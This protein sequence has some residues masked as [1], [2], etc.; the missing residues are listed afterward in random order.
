MVSQTEDCHWRMAMNGEETVRVAVAHLHNTDAKKNGTAR[1]AFFDK[2]AELCAGGV[3]LLAADLNLAM[4]GLVP[5]MTKRGVGCTLSAY[6]MELKDF[7]I[8]YDTLG[9]WTIGPMDIV[10]SCRIAPSSHMYAGGCHPQMLDVHI[11]NLQKGF[12]VDEHCYTSPQHPNT[13]HHM[14]QQVLIEI[15]KEAEVHPANDPEMRGAFGEVPWHDVRTLPK[16]CAGGNRVYAEIW[17]MDKEFM[18]TDPVLTYMT[19]NSTQQPSM[20]KTDHLPMFPATMEM[21]AV[22]KMWDPFGH[23]WGR[24]SH[25][26]LMVAVGL[27]RYRS[28]TMKKKRLEKTLMKKKQKRVDRALAKKQ[29]AA[30]QGQVCAGGQTDGSQDVHMS[31]PEQPQVQPDTDFHRIDHGTARWQGHILTWWHGRWTTRIHGWCRTLQG[32]NP[33]LSAWVP[34]KHRWQ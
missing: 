6:H 11:D 18:V 2:F 10:R 28:Q 34:G 24:D 22:A 5:E 13:D 17:R 4:F 8:R 16:Y 33:E 23:R 25:W 9:I 31:H 26:P 29:A 27:K 30:S 3:R 14:I 21:L 20:P 1:K 15:D 12:F 32:P 7:R 19:V